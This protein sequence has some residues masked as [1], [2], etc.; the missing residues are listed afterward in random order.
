VASRVKYVANMT[1]TKSP[2]NRLDT[3]V[4]RERKSR[5]RDLMFASFVALAT[6]IGMT[7]V[8]AACQAASPVHVVSR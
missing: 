1:N 7:S 8:S 4:A 3:I 5:V 6:I 2:T